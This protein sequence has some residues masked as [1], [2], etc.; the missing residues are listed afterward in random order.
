MK[1]MFIVEFREKTNNKRNYFIIEEATIS[2]AFKEAEK[3]CKIKN[4]KMIGIR[5]A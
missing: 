3:I 4:A 1:T 2:K 5:E